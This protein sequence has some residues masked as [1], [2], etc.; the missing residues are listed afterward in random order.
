MFQLKNKIESDLSPP[1]INMHKLSIY[2]FQ[3]NKKYEKEKGNQSKSQIHQ[4]LLYTNKGEESV[5]ALAENRFL[6]IFCV[7][8]PKNRLS[9]YKRSSF[10]TKTRV[11]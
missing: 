7:Y 1:K 11:F 5:F 9:W 10:F 8:I 3:K 4:I 6:I 2:L